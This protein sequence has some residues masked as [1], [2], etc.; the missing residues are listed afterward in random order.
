M[1]AAHAHFSLEIMPENS[2]LTFEGAWD[3]IAISSLIRSK[4][5]LDEMPAFLFLGRM[6]ANLLQHYLADSFGDDNVPNV[7]ECYYMGLKVVE[8]E[9][10]SFLHVGGRKVIRLLQDPIARRP[11]WRDNDTDAL[12]QLRI[13]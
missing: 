9:M 13:A 5:S 2:E 4:C 3:S 1:K 6:E 7:H 11:A 8:L 12:W 10:D